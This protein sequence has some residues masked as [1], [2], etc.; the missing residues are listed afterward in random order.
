M[1]E[2][3]NGRD[4]GRWVLFVRKLE[5]LAPCSCSWKDFARPVQQACFLAQQVLQKGTCGMQQGLRGCLAGRELMPCGMVDLTTLRDGS[6]SSRIAHLG[7]T[8]SSRQTSTSMEKRLVR[9]CVSLLAMT[10]TPHRLCEQSPWLPSIHPATAPANSFWK[11]P[12]LTP[13]NLLSVL[14][15]QRPQFCAKSG[16][17]HLLASPPPALGGWA[18]APLCGT[19][20]LWLPTLVCP[21]TPPT[22]LSLPPGPLS[23]PGLTT[24]C[25]SSLCKGYLPRKAFP[26]QPT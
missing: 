4:V 10:A 12:A 8:C 24:A 11:W 3:G 16:L 23:P 6:G 9:G 21:D 7:G 5:I 15:H 22:G 14:S 13:Q 25:L 17:F 20:S 26:G 18:G 19:G 2:Q 1:E